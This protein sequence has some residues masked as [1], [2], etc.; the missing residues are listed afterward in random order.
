MT[1]SPTTGVR[2]TNTRQRLFDVGLELF[3]RRGYDDVTTEEIAAA[4]GVS[5][6]T[7]FRHFASK[8][9]LLFADA[10]VATDEF[11]E[12]LYRQPPGP[13]TD[14][15][16]AAIAEQQRSLPLDETAAIVARIVNET[17]SLEE[18]RRGYERRFEQTL[19]E[20]IAQRHAVRPDNFD[21]RVLAAVLVA[22][23]RVCVNEWQAATGVGSVVPLASRALSAIDDEALSFS[24]TI[25]RSAPPPPSGRAD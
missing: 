25:D 12:L 6:R 5:Q 7:L 20:W 19:A 22:A 3:A 16:L 17:P 18:A 15:V 9:D 21:V 10:D 11:T 14:A 2:R 8:L 13:V 1:E 23:R 4:A 24:P